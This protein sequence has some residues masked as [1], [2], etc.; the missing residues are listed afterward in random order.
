MDERLLGRFYRRG[1]WAEKSRAKG[2][3]TGPSI[4]L[5]WQAQHVQSTA[6]GAMRTHPGVKVERVQE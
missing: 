4:A 6:G 1:R 5:T 2:A 3:V